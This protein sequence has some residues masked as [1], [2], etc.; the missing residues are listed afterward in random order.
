M[1]WQAHFHGKTDVQVKSFEGKKLHRKSCFV[2]TSKMSTRS[3][4][5]RVVKKRTVSD[6]VLSILAS[7]S[8]KRCFFG[9]P[10]CSTN[11]GVCRDIQISRLPHAYGRVSVT[12]ASCRAH[13]NTLHNLCHGQHCSLD[14]P[15]DDGRGRLGLEYER[16]SPTWSVVLGALSALAPASSSARAPAASRPGAVGGV[17]GV[18]LQVLGL[19]DPVEVSPE[20]LLNLLAL[21]VFLE[22]SSTLGLLSLLG[23][24]SE[25]VRQV[26]GEEH[27]RRRGKEKSLM[28][29]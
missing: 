1:C 23:E 3:F 26:T 13:E 21:S 28:I 19:C 29:H 6:Q 16:V 10:D 5:G 17:I 22:V 27:G 11:H 12:S 7:I 18:A 24:L 15:H 4:L 2:F 20:I 14:Q 25:V 8:L 9:G